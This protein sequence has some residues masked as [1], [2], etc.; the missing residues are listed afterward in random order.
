MLTKILQPK[1]NQFFST[2]S[3]NFVTWSWISLEC[4]KI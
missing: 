2:I 1:K 4:N 3:D